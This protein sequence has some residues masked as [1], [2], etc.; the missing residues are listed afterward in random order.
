MYF[1]IWIIKKKILLRFF[2]Q[3]QELI[4]NSSFSP[5]HFQYPKYQKQ[6]LIQYAKIS[7][8]NLISI[9]KISETNLIS[10]CKISDT[11]LINNSHWSCLCCKSQID[12]QPRLGVQATSH[13]RRSNVMTLHRQWCDAGATICAHWNTFLT[14]TLPKC[15]LQSKL[16]RLFNEQL[17]VQK[18]LIL[19]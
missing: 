19:A 7:E 9:R 1:N 12:P 3:W 10:I 5:D 15:L 14:E 4:K 18:K 11:N 8:T 17:L 2:V 13:Q 16:Y 6:I